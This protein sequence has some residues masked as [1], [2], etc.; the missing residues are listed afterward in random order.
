MDPPRHSS[1]ARFAFP[2]G[3]DAELVTVITTD[4]SGEKVQA[5]PSISVGYF[6]GGRLHVDE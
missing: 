6:S 2:V 1:V 5:R 4:Q 3:K